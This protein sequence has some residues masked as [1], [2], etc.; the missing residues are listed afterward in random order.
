M[1][2]LKALYIKDSVLGERYLIQLSDF[3]RS[4]VTHNNRQSTT[5]E[6]E[7]RFCKNY[8]E[9]QKIRFGNA[10]IWDLDFTNPEMLK[11]IVP[12]FSLQPLLENAIKHNVFTQESPLKITVVQTGN[13]ITVSNLINRRNAG[14]ASV[15]S[16]LGNLAERYLLW[17]G[18]EIIIKNDDVQFSVSIKIMKDEDR[19][20]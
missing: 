16:G 20:H 8:I 6:E 13:V 10:L 4:A 9:M 19:N 7:L 1:N 15:N 12:S 14:E 18:E 3:L 2:T 17:C 11:G 5:L